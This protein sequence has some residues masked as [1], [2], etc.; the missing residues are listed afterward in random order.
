MI[1]S[2][3][4]QSIPEL[5]DYVA[6]GAKLEI[7]GS[8]TKRG[9]GRPLQAE[10]A[11]DMS[12]FT[13]ISLY[14][15]E[16]LVLE[17]G[18]GTALS[19]IEKALAEHNQ[20]L[21]FE[22]PD[23]SK[24]LGVR[25]SGTLGGLMA[26]G[27]S[28]P[29]RIKAGAARDHI[30]GIAGVSGRGEVFKAGGRVVKNVTGFDVAKLMTGSFGTL[31]ALTSITVKVLPAAATEETLVFNGLSDAK[32]TQA[33]SSAMQ[34]ACEVSGAAHLPGTPSQT[35]FRLEGIQ[36]S[37]VYRRQ[38][39]ASHLKIF[40]ACDHL[41]EKESRLEWKA[42]R[43]VER[44]SADDARF[45]WKLSLTPS[46]AAETVARI[47]KQLDVQYFYDWAGGLVWLGVPRSNQAYAYIIRKCVEDGHATLFRAEDDVRERIEVFQPQ[48]PA[49]AGLTRRVKASFDPKGVFNHGRMYK[50]I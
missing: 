22:P 40:G 36:P 26:C 23:Y 35:L 47:S 29:R 42:I 24:L 6:I 18:A 50:D 49:L 14:E 45:V 11:L 20:Q 9:L 12:G 15:P 4:P 48:L 39:L 16:E 21:A 1:P 27:L 13:G 38:K 8:G 17:A 46:K 2:Y 31:A 28:G 32:A 25:H 44:L 30:L 43:D 41:D 10:T 5:A 3:K 33:M 37:V 19:D 34:S 7:I